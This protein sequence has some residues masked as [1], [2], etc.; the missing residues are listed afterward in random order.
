MNY[1]QISLA[2]VNSTVG[3][4]DGNVEKILSFAEQAKKIGS[5]AVVFPEMVITGYPPY[6]L[7]ER[8]S[9]I[10]SNLDAL[11]RIVQQAPQIDLYLGYVQP[12]DQNHGKNLYNACAYINKGTIES[13]H[14]KKLLPTYDV[15]NEARYFES[16]T[17]PERT[18][19]GKAVGISICE[20]FW[21]HVRPEHTRDQPYY[22]RDPF[23]ELLET[24]PEILVNLSASPFSRG[25]P[26]ERETMFQRMARE[27][28]VPLVFCNQVGGNDSL[29]FDG[30][31][32]V[33][34]GEGNLIGSGRAFE[35][36]L[37]TVNLPQTSQQISTR[38]LPS[39][40]AS[41]YS[42][43]K[44]GLR[45]YFEKCGF[46]EAVVGLSG[47][48]DSS[49]TATIAADVLGSAN[50]LGVMMPSQISSDHSVTDAEKL[51]ANLGI[52]TRT[53]AIEELFD[54]YL[55]L[56]EDEFQGT[57]WDATEENLQAR[58]R[59]NILMALSNKFGYLVLS[60]GNKSELAVGYCTL[61]GDMNGGLAVLSD[62]PKTVVYD[63]C[64]HRN[65]QSHVIPEHVLEKPP[66]AELSPDQKDQD[67]LPPYE[68]LDEI[69][70]RYVEKKQSQT[71]IKN[72]GLESET[73]EE[74]V[75]MIDRN[76]Y[77]RRQAPPGIKVTS[78]AFSAGRIIPIA[79]KL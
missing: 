35:E 18:G 74:V 19:P 6:D 5:Q 27:A 7:L 39:E 67:S 2:Q 4:F 68:I 34:D 25:K 8:S 55:E 63:L 60:T 69:I 42:A 37:L 78:K 48:I 49:L 41:I 47:G 20:D 36:D 3:D 54:G 24:E 56:F 59:G 52:D 61:Y 43:L 62:V 12:R 79:Q 1:N 71:E 72:A 11:Q 9:F 45:D 32:M 64:R 50:V 14:Y 26:R 21:N 15:F 28:G 22:S 65:E 13:R 38:S 77:K 75:E 17:Q 58:I 33:F 10:Q 57:E 29:V 51:A 40:V 23:Q 46:S 53:Y 16:G 44:L 31:S 76:E 70:E 73:V 30:N 66:S